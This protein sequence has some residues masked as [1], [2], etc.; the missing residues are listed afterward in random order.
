M[1][2][3]LSLKVHYPTV[4]LGRWKGLYK[5]FMGAL[6]EFSI[7]LQELPT[8]ICEIEADPVMTVLPSQ[9]VLGFSC[10]EHRGLSVQIHVDAH[11]SM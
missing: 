4:S 8:L 3:F 5:R 7:G 6:C 1:L 10:I 2:S 9:Q 11:A